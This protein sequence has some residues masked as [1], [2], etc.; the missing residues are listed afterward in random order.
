M[1]QQKIFH[2]ELTIGQLI[3]EEVKKQ[4]LSDAEF[5]RMI[6]CERANVGK[7]YK[8]ASIDTAQLGLI[9]RVLKR[10]FF[11]D[12]V[13]NPVLSGVDNVE[14]MQEVIEKMAVSQFI[15]TVP[16]VL[17]KM[18]YSACLHIGRPNDVPEEIAFPDY[19]IED[20]HI[21][22]SKGTFLI[23][24]QNCELR[25]YARVTRY[26]EKGTGY[27]AD[28]WK[29]YG[30]GIPMIDIILD[31][32]SEKDWEA[33]I[34]WVLQRFFSH[35]KIAPPAK[36]Q[37]S[38]ELEIIASTMHQIKQEQCVLYNEIS[39]N[40]TKTVTIY[41]DDMMDEGIEFF[42]VEYEIDYNIGEFEN[43]SAWIELDK[44]LEA[45]SM[46]NYD[47]LKQY[48]LE[49]YQGEKKAWQMIVKE[50]KDKGI[51]IMEDESEGGYTGMNG[52]FFMTNL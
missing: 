45:Y 13:Q 20:L 51:D 38:Y 14:A 35:L 19:F 10:N 42:H 4:H 37:T 1:K 25:Q 33:V 2:N 22:F 30:G 3:K 39:A 17:K 5:G 50:F 7:I 48:L 44:I 47:T 23:E 16:K 41:T 15:D 18:G 29:F 12:I 31:Y 40:R 46:D 26:R 11:V 34:T 49:K 32:K 52:E 27:T 36:E 6:F 43:G 21:N 8:R 28:L 9:S 24:K